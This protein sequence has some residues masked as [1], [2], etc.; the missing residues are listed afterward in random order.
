MVC[1]GFRA[2]TPERVRNWR[3]TRAFW[4]S[5]GWEVFAGDD[6]GEVFSVGRSKNAAAED[7]G[8]WDVAVF[9]DVDTVPGSVKQMQNAVE[10]ASRTGHFTVAYST[11]HY[12]AEAPSAAV[13]AGEADLE[14][15]LAFKSIGLTWINTFAV[16]R[17]LWD[18]VGGFDHRIKGYGGEDL[19][20]YFAAATLTGDAK[21]TPGPLYHLDHPDNSE[22]N[23]VDGTWTVVNAY[24]HA[25]W[26]VAAMREVIAGNK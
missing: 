6:P 22:E 8:E 14:P 13:C 10:T 3:Y 15:D 26:D 25:K 19:A 16:T 11:L 2:D 17:A 20:F 1:T 12:L 18:E 21:R 4:D 9:T 7:A 5:T 23:K 24:S